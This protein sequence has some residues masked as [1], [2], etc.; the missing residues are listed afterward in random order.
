MS[1]GVFGGV[2]R[3]WGGRRKAERPLVLQGTLGG[4][5]RKDE[6]WRTTHGRVQDLR[7]VGS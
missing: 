2:A 6:V 7:T 4:S 5:G 1:L 3:T